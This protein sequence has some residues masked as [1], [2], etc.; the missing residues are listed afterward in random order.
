MRVWDPAG[1]LELDQGGGW[2]SPGGSGV[3]ALRRKLEASGS[4]QA[5]AT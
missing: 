2:T 4:M 1:L 5:R 3:T